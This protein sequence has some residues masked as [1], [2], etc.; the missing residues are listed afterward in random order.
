MKTK[1]KRMG[2]T[3]LA[4]VLLLTTML[5][6]TA[7]AAEVTMDISKAEVSWDYTLTDAEGN[8]F[9]AAYGLHAADDY[10]GGKGFNAYASKMHDYTA[11]R[12]NLTSNKSEWVYGQDYVYC[13]CIERGIPLPNKNDYA[14]SSDLTH[15]DK[16]ERLS[17][18][19]KDLLALALTYGYP[20]RTGL[21]TS[22]DA[23]ACYAATQLI[24]LQ[25][26]MGFRSS[27]TE[28]ND[29][30]YPMSGYS[31]TMTAQSHLTNISKRIMTPFSRIWL[32]TKPGRALQEV[33]L[34]P[35]LFTK[36]SIQTVSTR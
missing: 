22:A 16:Y 1:M 5:P 32:Y 34:E 19:Q 8:A 28:L 2:S 9:S 31:G 20:N 15:G 35:L 4:L 12:T 6:L 26:T 29:K 33:S 21:S 17:D 30:T 24:I 27:A 13:F 14:G 18:E 25:I 23:N 11:K 36:W 7:Q 3:I 10:Y